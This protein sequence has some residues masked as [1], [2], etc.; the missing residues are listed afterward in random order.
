VSAINPPPA[1]ERHSS[2]AAAAL[3]D[4]ELGETGFAAAVG[5]S[6]GFGSV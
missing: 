5:C 6:A 1:V 3:T 2:A 4:S